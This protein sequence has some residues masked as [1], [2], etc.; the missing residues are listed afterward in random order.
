[1]ELCSTIG[2]F[3]E[4]VEAVCLRAFPFSLAGKAK[5]WLQSHPNKSLNTWEEVEEKFITRFLPPS[6]FISAKPFI[7]TFSQGSHKPLCETW[8]RFKALLQRCL[9][10]NFDDIA[11]MH[12]FHSGLKPQTKMI[13]DASAG[14]TMMSKSPDGSFLEKLL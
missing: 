3:N 9:N 14:G 1:M 11:Q 4:D 6:R 13:L 12:I 2:A 8:E 5:T 7:M 10:H